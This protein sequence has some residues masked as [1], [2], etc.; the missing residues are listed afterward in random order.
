MPS[1]SGSSSFPRTTRP[2]WRSSTRSGLTVANCVPSVPALLQLAI[3]GMEGPAD[4]EQRI[5]AICASVRRFAAYEPECVLCVTGPL[6]NRLEAE[7]TAIVVDG[8]R[9]IASAAREAGV[10]LGFEPI[11]PVG[12]DI[13]LVGRTPCRPLWGFSTKRDSTTS[14]SWSTP[15]TS[16]MTST[17]RRGCASMR[18]VSP[19]CTSQLGVPGEPERL[20]PGEAGERDRELIE[21]LRAGGWDGTLDVEIFFH[22]RRVLEPA[23]R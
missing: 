7:A 17:R 6:G 16:G 22:A 21:A 12:R 2:I 4:P 23:G 20:L 11:P 19:A 15:T 5:T 14:G 3:P 1:V 18:R 13:D 9:R 8:L 10:R